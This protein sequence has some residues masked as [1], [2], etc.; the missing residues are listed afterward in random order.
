MAT[1]HQTRTWLHNIQVI[2]HRFTHWN[3]WPITQ[4]NC[5]FSCVIKSCIRWK[6]DLPNV[7]RK[8][9]VWSVYLRLL[10]IIESN[11]NLVV[12]ILSMRGSISLNFRIMFWK[13]DLSE[14]V[15]LHRSSRNEYIFSK[16]VCLHLRL[17]NQG[18]E[19]MPRMHCS[20]KAYCTTLLTPLMF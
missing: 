1:T 13:S 16:G 2:H 4:F 19:H 12:T 10:H 3:L 5:S 20:L 15:Y 6:L 9:S 18:M 14:T 17:R 8:F 11:F 7:S